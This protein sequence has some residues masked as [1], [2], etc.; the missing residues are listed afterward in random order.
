MGRTLRGHLDDLPTDQLDVVLGAE[1]SLCDHRL[2]LPASPL[3]RAHAH[4][5]VFASKPVRFCQCGN[6][7]FI[8]RRSYPPGGRVSIRGGCQPVRPLRLWLRRQCRS[9]R[10]GHRRRQPGWVA[11]QDAAV[12]RPWK[13]P[14]E[15]ADGPICRFGRAIG[16]WKPEIFLRLGVRA[17]CKIAGRL[18]K[19]SERYPAPFSEKAQ[20]RIAAE[21]SL[22]AELAQELTHTGIVLQIPRRQV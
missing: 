21:R 1:H 16:D 18:L 19:S 7:V 20:M 3:F 10:Q 14:S 12:A 5:V 6:E 4:V 2:I 11:R 17:L 22:M 13:T 8:Q 9:A 15:P